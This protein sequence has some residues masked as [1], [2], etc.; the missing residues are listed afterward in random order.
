MILFELV[1]WSAV[2]V[3]GLLVTVIAHEFTH[4]VAVW[5]VANS[6]RVSVA[7]FPTLSV[8]ADIP[9]TDHAQ[10][11]ADAAGAAP[12]VV[13]IAVALG[14]TLTGTLPI[15]PTLDTVIA[16]FCWFIFTVG[17]PSDHVRRVSLR[18]GEEQSQ[19]DDVADAD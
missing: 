2:M 1:Y 19:S 16:W 6:V 15:E 8:Q 10:R 4:V 18:R 3:G 17:S 13:G 9:D 12:M 7:N 14:A 11:V 5:P